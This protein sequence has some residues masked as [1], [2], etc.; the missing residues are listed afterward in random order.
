MLRRG[1]SLSLRGTGEP[2]RGT[3]NRDFWETDEGGSRN[4]AFLYEEVHYGGPLGRAPLLGSLEDMLR[5]A[6]DMGISLHRGPVGESGGDSL[7]W[8][9]ERKG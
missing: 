2:G 9:F 1:A 8:T 3:S 7:A 6:L 4:G 5:K